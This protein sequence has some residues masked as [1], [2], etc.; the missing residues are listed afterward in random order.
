MPMPSPDEYQVYDDDV[1]YNKKAGD[2]DDYSDLIELIED[3]LWADYLDSG[4]SG[5]T[6]I[7]R[8]AEVVDVDSQMTY[9]AIQAMLQNRDHVAANYH[10]SLQRSATYEPMWEVYPYDLDTS[11]GCVFDEVDLNNICDDLTH[12]IWWLN[13]LVP[14][15]TMA[16]HPTELWANLL[17]HLVLAEPDCQANFNARLCE[18]L[19]GEYWNERLPDL[20]TALQQTLSASVE[21]DP[22]DLNDDLED[23]DEAVVG[24]Q[25]F[26]DDRRDHLQ[27]QLGCSVE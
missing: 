20:A 27:E 10:I 26:L 11:F 14:D 9:L 21:V 5:P 23:F 8:T 4:T 15:G 3:V 17:I 18:R 24:F 6:S 13:G 22:N 12:D 7:E 1:V 25:A 16:G 19:D 2:E